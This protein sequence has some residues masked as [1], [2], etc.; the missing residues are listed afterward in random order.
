MERGK[1]REGIELSGSIPPELS[2]LS[3]LI[4]LDLFNNQLTGSIPAELSDLQ[5]LRYLDLNTNRLSGS[6]PAELGNLR[7]LIVLRLFGNQ[8]SGSIPAEFGH[9]RKLEFVDLRNN[10]LSGSIPAELGGLRSLRRILLSENQLSGSIPDELGYLQRLQVL[11]V[12]NNRLSGE[13]PAELRVSDSLKFCN[14]QI[15]GSLADHLRIVVFNFSGDF[16]DVASCYE[17]AFS[18]DDRAINEVDI[19]QLALWEI[20]KGCG[21][22]RFCPNQIATRAQMAAFLYRAYAYLYGTPDPVEEEV[23]FSDA[24]AD[25]WYWTYAQ[26]AVANEIMSA[27]DG[28]FDSQ[29]PLTAITEMVEMLAATFDYLPAPAALLAFFESS[30]PVD[31]ASFPPIRAAMASFLVNVITLGPSPADSMG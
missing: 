14:N 5:D 3:D 1:G 22:N 31:V 2:K 27:P 18:D 10:R 29:A 19:D 7:N 23:Q 28:R 4:Y 8:L 13:I 9:L 20:T 15:T 25:A 6:I 16:D 17:G 30:F 26:W 12:Q 24:D 21:D 11:W